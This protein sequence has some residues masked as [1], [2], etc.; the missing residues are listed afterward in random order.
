MQ[1]QVRPYRNVAK[2]TAAKRM[3]DNKPHALP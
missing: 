1:L 3:K 2:T